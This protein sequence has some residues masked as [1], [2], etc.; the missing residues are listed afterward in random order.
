M[1]K[2]YIFFIIAASAIFALQA[3][4]VNNLYENYITD[5]GEYI[6]NKVKESIDPQNYLKLFE[7]QSLS[8][9]ITYVVEY[10]EMESNQKENL[11][12]AKINT[13]LSS[14]GD[15]KKLLQQEGSKE[16]INLKLTLDDFFENDIIINAD[17]LSSLFHK[18]LNRDY[19]CI[20]ELHNSRYIVRNLENHYNNQDWNFT[21][22]N[23]PVGLKGYQFIR[24]YADIPVSHFIENTI[25]ILSASAL[26]MLL[27]LWLLLYLI[28]VI[29]TKQRQITTRE[30]NIYGM[31]HDLKSPLSGVAMTLDY[32]KNSIHNE[33]IEKIF[34]LNQSKINHMISGINSLLRVVGSKNQEQTIGLTRQELDQ[35][36]EIITDELKDIHSHKTAKFTLDLD[37]KD[38][39]EL[40]IDRLNLENILRNLMDNSIKYSDK[41]VEITVRVQELSD[42]VEFQI[43][44]NGWGIAKKYQRKVF[45][46]FYQVPNPQQN[47][48]YGIGLCYVRQIVKQKQGKIKLTSTLNQGTTITFTIPK[49]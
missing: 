26:I 19:S 46:N 29:R 45:R 20:I 37:F 13:Y 4:L 48:G 36:L 47:Q 28:V 14:E 41:E 10:K 39:T 40:N 42:K 17:S 6:E 38:C 16:N 22:T 5:E 2:F 12:L 7:N 43:E 33:Q 30:N 32:A 24:V 35:S 44:D 49:R 31:M 8:N 15:L 3:L 1:K 23:Y 25:W 21:L 27:I 11:V 9:F 18:N 34:S